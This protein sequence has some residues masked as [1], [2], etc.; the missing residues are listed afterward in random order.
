MNIGWPQGIYIAIVLLGL[1][2]TAAKDGE[3]ME[4][5]YNFS[6]R[7]MLSICIFGLLWWGGFFG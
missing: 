2:I 5:R 6:L 4:G 3:P 1:L 7:F